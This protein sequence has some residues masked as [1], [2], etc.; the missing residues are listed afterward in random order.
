V[1]ADAQLTAL[2]SR[3]GHAL[4]P[5]SGNYR[6]FRVQGCAAG[7]LND[8]RAKRLA[9]M[10]DV[11]VVR[12]DEIRFVGELDDEPRRSAAMS[13][14]THDLACAGELSPW[15]GEPYAVAP[16]LGAPP[17]FVLE[18]AAARYFG[19]HTYAAHVNGVVRAD[20]NV[21]MWLARRSDTKAIDPGMLDNLV[22]GGIAAGKSVAATVVKEAW[23]EAGIPTPLACLAH[24]AGTVQIWREQP[25]GL[26]H[27]TI[28]VHDLWLPAAFLPVGHD[29]EV[30]DHRLVPL[31][32]AARLI[33]A[34]RGLD[35][36]TADASLVILD[37]LIRHSQIAQQATAYPTLD[38]LR[39]PA[40]SFRGSSPR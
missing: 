33:G 25:D 2:C 22:G 35:V 39:H 15:R 30:V 16:A 3:L 9:A 29:G 40:T 13:R 19:I 14:V 18:R 32:E 6:P 10:T 23:E 8:A 20:H 17:W 21:L 36:V 28:F 24:N 4:T 5:P 31:A 34:E 12:D 27:E 26:Q 1:I 37:F 11:F 38:A 7:W